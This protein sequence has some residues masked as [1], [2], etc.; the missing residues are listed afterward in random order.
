MYFVMWHYIAP[1]SCINFNIY[2]MHVKSLGLC[3]PW[4]LDML[5][6]LIGT[7]SGDLY[8]LE[9]VALHLW[10]LLS[11]NEVWCGILNS[12]STLIVV[13]CSL[14]RLCMAAVCVSVLLHSE[15]RC[16]FL[17]HLPH[18]EFLALHTLRVLPGPVWG[19]TV[20]AAL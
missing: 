12:L 6:L 17:P 3:Y 18:I 9:A 7:Q 5:T 16:P 1:S 13:L 11:G 8:S 20:V 2:L 10:Q 15:S 19:T 14:L 4:W